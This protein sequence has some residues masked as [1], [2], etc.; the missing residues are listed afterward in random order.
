MRREH[1]YSFDSLKAKI[2]LEPS[3]NKHLDYQETQN[4]VPLNPILSSFTFPGFGR[5]ELLITKAHLE[6]KAAPKLLQPNNLKP[7]KILTES[8]VLLKKDIEINVKTPEKK[9]N[10]GEISSASTE[11]KV[12]SPDQDKM[13]KCK[14]SEKKSPKNKKTSMSTSQ[15]S[16][17]N[18]CKCKKSKCLK[19]YCECFS[20]G[21]LCTEG[22]SCNNCTNKTN[23]DNLERESAIQSLIAKNPNIF[24]TK[25]NFIT[26]CSSTSKP[27]KNKKTNN[28][29]TSHDKTKRGCNCKKSQCQKKY[30]ECYEA[31]IKCEE[32]C[33]CEDCKN[34]TDG[35]KKKEE[36]HGKKNKNSINKENLTE[37]DHLIKKKR[38]LE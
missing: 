31:G 15:L 4:K 37:G 6:N 33:K 25:P 7:K 16:A 26:L 22:C 38:R 11:V 14:S 36:I 1:H 29:N 3:V 23:D 9:N 21:L 34:T 35:K 19:L 2:L 13:K 5:N 30:C 17:E 20:N 27:E 32:Y 28:T 8:D 12:N 24:N 18:G 10:N